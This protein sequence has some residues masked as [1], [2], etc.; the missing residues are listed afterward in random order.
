MV[1]GQLSAMLCNSPTELYCCV[2]NQY[3]VQ[4][5]IHAIRDSSIGNAD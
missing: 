2:C 3:N 4:S 1:F 5:I